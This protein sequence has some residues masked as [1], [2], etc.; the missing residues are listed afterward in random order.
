MKDIIIDSSYCRENARL[1]S[2]EED[3]YTEIVTGSAECSDTITNCNPSSYRKLNDIVSYG[4][5]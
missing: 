3:N 4:T 2:E 1:V 5:I